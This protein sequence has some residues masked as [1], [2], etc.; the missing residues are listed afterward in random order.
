ME[1]EERGRGGGGEGGEGG[2]AEE[3]APWYYSFR[4][5]EFKFQYPH[6]VVLTTTCNSSSSS[7]ICPRAAH[8]HRDTS[9][10]I[11]R[12][13]RTIT[14]NF[15]TTLKKECAGTKDPIA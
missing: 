14:S 11:Y 8:I 3:M 10:H 15:K 4:G 13:T 6:Q 7:G 9:T 2:G 1:E 5:S 12:P